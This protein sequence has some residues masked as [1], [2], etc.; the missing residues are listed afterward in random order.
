MSA[1]KKF[2]EARA[3]LREKVTGKPQKTDEE[4][5]AE[6]EIKEKEQTVKSEKTIV[7]VL[8]HA[9]ELFIHYKLIGSIEIDSTLFMVTNSLSCDVTEEDF[10]VETTSTSND[11]KKNALENSDEMVVSEEDV[12]SQMSYSE[13]MAIASI[14]KMIK[15]LIM[16]SE[17]YKNTSFN[18]ALEL[19]RTINFQPPLPIQVFSLSVGLSATVTSL[20]NA[21]EK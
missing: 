20:L 3:N 19:S 2:N 21:V 16:R 9:R 1:F 13:K 5:L 12:N 14:R 8:N 11:T 6:E 4:I 7:A 17:V 15:H 10:V 18:S